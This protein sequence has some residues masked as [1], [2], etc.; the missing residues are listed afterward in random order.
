MGW[1][2]KKGLRGGMGSARVEKDGL[3]EQE[4]RLGSW[5]GERERTTRR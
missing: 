1:P 5:F 2:P 4:R 3:G